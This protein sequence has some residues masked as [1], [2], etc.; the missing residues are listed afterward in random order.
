MDIEIF[1]WLHS[2][3]GH[4]PIVDGLA[5]FFAETGPYL[6]LALFV[7]LWF[8]VSKE[9]KNALLEATEAAVVGL[10]MNQ[11]VGL[12]YFHPRPY[13]IG[14]CTPL[15]PHGPETSFPSDHATL[16]FAATF[17]LLMGRRWVNCGVTVLVIAC[18]TAWGRVYSGIH[19]P[20]DMAGS[21]VVGLISTGLIRWFAERLA[22]L[23]IKLIRVSD[24][25]MD[26][27]VR[28]R[29]RGTRRH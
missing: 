25:L 15:L 22:P 7:A 10:I 2:G 24:Q 28:P 23:N 19:F 11:L 4:R 1:Q 14:L 21:L 20:F 16:L 8:F 3:A 13:M 12:F 9:K 18:L 27:V 29:H 5:V 6:M 17:Y 26:H